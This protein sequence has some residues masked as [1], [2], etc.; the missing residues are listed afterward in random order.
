MRMEFRIVSRVAHGPNFYEGI[1]AAVLDKDNAPRW[2]P[3][4]LA[5]VSEAAVAAHFAPLAEEL[6]L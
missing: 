1:R 2:N 4:H 5:E 3:P 6:P